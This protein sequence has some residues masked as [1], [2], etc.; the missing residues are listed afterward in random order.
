VVIDRERVVFYFVNN[1]DLGVRTEEELLGR[2][3]RVANLL[4]TADFITRG[5]VDRLAWVLRVLALC[6]SRLEGSMEGAR[7]SGLDEVV[8]SARGKG[9]IPWL[10]SDCSGRRENESGDEKER[11]ASGSG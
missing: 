9:G 4:E 2:D 7:C 1:V 10:V 11:R 6:E 5:G 3:S 8:K